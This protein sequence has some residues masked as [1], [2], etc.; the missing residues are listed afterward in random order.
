MKGLMCSL[1]QHQSITTTLPKAKELRPFAEK[2]ITRAKKGGLFNRRLVIARLGDITMGSCLVDTI[3]PQI[4]RES[5]YLRITKL[6]ARR[7][8]NAPMAEISFVD[9]IKI[10]AP[11]AAEVKPAE[12]KTTP[13]KKSA[14]KA[15]PATKV[16]V[17]AKKG[18]K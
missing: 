16:T 7:G 9:E 2:L 10:D 11:V 3:A 12:K 18:E 14:T 8:D 4:K 6:E 5:G 15:K 1:I 13:A 17:A